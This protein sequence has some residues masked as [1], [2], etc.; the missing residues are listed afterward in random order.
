MTEQL[1]S[2]HRE[3]GVL[4][5]TRWMKAEHDV[6]TRNAR[7]DQ[8]LCDR[9]RRAVVLNPGLTVDDINRTTDP[10]TRL[11]LSQPTCMTS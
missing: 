8:L 9:L 1:L 3:S 6:L 5:D 4:P 11:A 10:C 2:A 7:G